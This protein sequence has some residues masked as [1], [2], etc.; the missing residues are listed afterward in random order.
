[1]VVFDQGAKIQNVELI[2]IL[3]IQIPVLVLIG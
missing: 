3:L 2:L 1:L